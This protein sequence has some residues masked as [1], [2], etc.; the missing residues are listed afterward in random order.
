VK[1]KLTY[2]EFDALYR[3]FQQLCQKYACQDMIDKLL[4]VLMTS[5]FIKLHTMS[6]I[7]KEKYSVKMSEAEAIAFWEVLSD[8][9]LD[10]E[11]FEG[12]L[13]NII[14]QAIHQKFA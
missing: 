11:T 1:L 6:V 8:H 7:K 4:H 2:Q 9:K 13:L 14:C 12:N 3:I 10:N 5:I